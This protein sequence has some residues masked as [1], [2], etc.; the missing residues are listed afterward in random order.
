MKILYFHQHFKT[1]A[2]AGGTR[3]YEMAKALIAAG[4]QVTMVCGEIAKLDLAPTKDKYVFRG[5]L[6]GIDVI[7]LM[8]PYSNNDPIA[9]RAITFLI[10][11]ETSPLP[12]R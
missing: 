12:K 6:D 11:T 2:Q 7:Q 10:R 5:E 9:K 3:S 4:P 8:F 1:L